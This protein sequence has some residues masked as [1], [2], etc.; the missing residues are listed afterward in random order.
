MAEQGLYINIVAR[1]SA[2]GV[3][4]EAGEA[5]EDMA[6]MMGDA[7][8]AAMSAGEQLTQAG[9][10]CEEMA[11][12]MEGASRSSTGLGRALSDAERAQ[13]AMSNAAVEAERAAAR[14]AEAQRNY[15]DAVAKYGS[16]S[17]EAM[18]AAQDLTVSQNN[19]ALAAD[20][21]AQA[22][23]SAEASVTKYSESA[24]KAVTGAS[25]LTMAGF[26]LY[27]TWDNIETKQRAL[28]NANL[29]LQNSQNVVA[30]AQATLN[31]AIEQYGIDSPQAALATSSLEN[32]QNRLMMAS[33]SAENAQGALNDAQTTAYITTIPSLIAGLKSAK[34]LYDGLV[35]VGP[36]VVTA[37]KGIDSAQALAS[38]S[39]FRLAAGAGAFAAIYVAFTTDSEETRVAMSLLAGAMMTAAVATWALNAAKAAG[40]TLSTLG[41]GA[42][43]VGV[44]LA[45]AAAIY[46]GASMFGATAMAEGGIVP[47]GSNVFALIGE[48]AND[49]AVIPLPRGYNAGN[50]G[51]ALGGGNTY[52]THEWHVTSTRADAREVAQEMYSLMQRKG[53]VRG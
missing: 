29:S 14:A 24:F 45:S 31:Q 38:S 5:A 18:S 16:N 46:A 32:A 10:A 43:L 3:F 53:G 26:S 44:A 42:L 21:L 37:I 6:E 25:A 19:A 49:E 34:D 35:D 47:A 30:K 15:N 36:K 27:K 8:D 52:V 48:G 39:A 20:K 7:G 22:S 2:R 4:K 12:E 28:E 1:D 23:E 33:N 17:L 13:I 40:L 50:L 11:E 9:Q 41:A 51:A